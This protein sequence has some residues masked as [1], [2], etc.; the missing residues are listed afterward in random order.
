[1]SNS[2]KLTNTYLKKLII[3][4]VRKSRKERIYEDGTEIQGAGSL[5]QKDS[6]SVPSGGPM[7]GGPDRATHP[8]QGAP[9]G[10]NAIAA[11]AD[12]PTS[13]EVLR[14]AFEAISEAFRNIED[15]RGPFEEESAAEEAENAESLDDTD[16]T[17]Q[18]YIRSYVRRR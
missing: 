9:V 10:W 6:P 13:E 4:E 18:E 17:L 1:M 2:D 11:A 15:G 8:E 12:D 5:P 7:M 14:G 16:P 3:E